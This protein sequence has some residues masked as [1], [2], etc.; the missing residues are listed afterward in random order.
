MLRL[1]NEKIKFT[2]FFVLI[3][4]LTSNIS[5]QADIKKYRKCQNKLKKTK[6]KI[7]IMKI[8]CKKWKF[9]KRYLAIFYST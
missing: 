3:T 6:I 2:N 4:I 5:T 1:F 7:H 9:I 8:S